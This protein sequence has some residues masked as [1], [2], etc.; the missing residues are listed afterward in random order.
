MKKIYLLSILVCM[1][2]GCGNSNSTKNKEADYGE[3]YEKACYAHDYE[4][5]HQILSVLRQNAISNAAL[6]DSF[7]TTRSEYLSALETVYT[8]ELTY[9]VLN[10]PE[11]SE[12]RISL[13]MNELQPL[14]V[15]PSTDRLD[16][17]EW[18]ILDEARDGIYV[19]GYDNNSYR[20]WLLSYNNICRKLL[21]LA[22]SAKNQHLAQKAVL[23]V[24]ENV[25]IEHV[26]YSIYYSMK[27]VNTDRDSIKSEYD[28]AVESGLFD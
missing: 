25:D 28:K 15:R 22:I 12:L 14:G 2:C 16:L 24:K 8:S 5:A 6:E 27:L 10:F 26:P 4:A 9:I 17:R 19:S 21:D 20:L 7:R 1:I 3:D 18:D 11:D 13:R 23:L